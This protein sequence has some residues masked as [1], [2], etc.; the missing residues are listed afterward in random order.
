MDTDERQVA[1]H[2]RSRHRLGARRP[3]YFWIEGRPNYSTRP[4]GIKEAKGRV[5]HWEA[6]NITEGRKMFVNAPGAEQDV[7]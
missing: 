7:R 6:Q 1:A 2:A 4:T 5:G 3:R